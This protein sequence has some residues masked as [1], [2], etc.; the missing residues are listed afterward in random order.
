M[1][2][3]KEQPKCG[4]YEL[5]T[6]I[7]RGGM[8]DVF[9]AF[10]PQLKRQV[11]V[12]LVRRRGGAAQARPSDAE[13]V[14][15]LEREART[16]AALTHAN[17]VRIFDVG[18]CDDGVYIA[19][20]LLEGDDGPATLRK[21]LRAE[22]RSHD[23]VIA[24]FVQAAMGLHAAH[25]ENL[26]H[27]DFKPANVLL[28]AQNIPKIA[29]FGLAMKD[30][31]S[32]PTIDSADAVPID[33]DR[34]TQT[35]ATVGTPRY[36]APEQHVSRTL[37]ARADQYAFAV[38]LYEA[39]TSKAPFQGAKAGD[40]Y[41]SKIAGLD[42]GP[43]FEALPKRVRQVLQRALSPNPAGRFESMQTLAE[44]L[45]E[46]PAWWQRHFVQVTAVVGVVALVGVV[47]SWLQRTEPSAPNLLS[48]TL[49]AGA[50]WELE[51]SS[52]LLAEGS[53]PGAR[54]AARRAHRWA[55]A[56][57]AAREGAI[58]LIEVGNVAMME[59]HFDQAVQAFGQ[60]YFLASAAGEHAEAGDAATRVVFALSVSGD[61]AK[62]VKW[63][64]HARSELERVDD[65]E[66]QAKFLLS[67]GLVQQATGD[68]RAAATSAHASA[69]VA[70]R[71][72]GRWSAEVAAARGN[73]GL[74]EM[75]SGDYEAA[76]ASFHDAMQ[77]YE[78]VDM[79][80]QLDYAVVV[81][82]LAAVDA[83][84][85][86]C[87]STLEGIDRVRGLLRAHPNGAQEHGRAELNAAFCL[88]EM[89]RL[90]EARSALT[91]SRQSLKEAF[92]DEN[93]FSVEL[94]IN[95]AALLHA[96]GKADAARSSLQG[97]REEHVARDGVDHFAVARIEHE[98]GILLREHGDLDTAAERLAHAQEVFAK[99]L[100]DAAEQ[101]LIARLE[102]ARTLA[103]LD[104]PTEALPILI[105]CEEALS[106]LGSRKAKL[107]TQYRNDVQALLGADEP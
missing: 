106:M 70:Q 94:S 107:A 104:G 89:S 22:R 32:S 11:A 33:D 9:R 54:V 31:L 67:A 21:W 3:R 79:Q 20:E 36:M 65:D 62:G 97:A 81:L 98:L 38:A 60:S 90:S 19:M 17:V 93:P 91:R 92:G 35:G 27:R 76:R 34:L 73:Q 102:H 96:E 101:T 105:E 53:Y 23:E 16:Q 46:A 50:L 37:D 78:R 24:M 55:D 25:L 8:G 64:S 15:R 66:L 48:N 84:V 41:Q 51:R 68:Y 86:D 58:A 39:L 80:G 18:R 56:G 75:S 1:L 12:K 57:G 71:V 49:R 14:R 77:T 47:T 28:T 29:D 88:V 13:V 59:G 45:V 95:E 61:S 44:A 52:A 6:Q 42:A 2:G 69:V 83:E 63:L 5:Q 7:G 43:E 100:G 4:R 30:T 10:D 99:A 72:F 103:E 82:N 74:A 40:L 87:E 26:V 85:G